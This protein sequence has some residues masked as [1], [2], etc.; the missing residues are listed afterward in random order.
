[1]HAPA[2][3]PTPFSLHQVSVLKNFDFAYSKYFE[4]KASPARVTKLLEI[5]LG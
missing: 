1:M 5:G 3:P 2:L 4:W